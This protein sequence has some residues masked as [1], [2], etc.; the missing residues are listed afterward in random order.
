MPI[1]DYSHESRWYNIL[2]NNRLENIKGHEYLLMQGSEIEIQNQHFTDD[3]IAADSKTN[4]VRISNS[5]TI[6]VDSI[7]EDDDGDNNDDDSYIVEL[8]ADETITIESIN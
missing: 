3:E 2:S 1:T 7:D 8:S 6:S 5:G 4:I